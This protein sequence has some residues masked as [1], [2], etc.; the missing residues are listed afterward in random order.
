MRKL[1]QTWFGRAKAD[2]ELDAEIQFHLDSRAADLRRAGM[3][4]REAERKA[5][6]EFGG[7][8]P[9]AEECRDSRPARWLYDLAQDLDYAWRMMKK[10]PVVSAAAVVSLALGIGANT[11]IFSLIDAIALRELPVASPGE[12]V[13]LN[14]R[15]T[16]RGPLFDRYSGSI[17]PPGMTGNAFSYA[18][19]EA[20]RQRREEFAQLATF[21]GIERYSVAAGGTT[22]ALSGQLVSGDYFPLLGIR[23]H[24]GRLLRP[25]DDSASA[26]LAAVVSHRFYTRAFGN[27]EARIGSVIRVNNR[28]AVLVGVTP[29]GFFG[30]E[31]GAFADI[32]LS[33]AHSGEVN[34]EFVSGMGSPFTNRSSWAFQM[35]GRLRNSGQPLGQREA[36]LTPVLNGVLDPQPKEAGLRPRLLLEPAAQGISGLRGLNTMF[37]VLLGSTMLVLLIASANV[38]N[39]LLARAMGRRREIAVRLSI[40]AS[41]G[42][43][44]R[45]IASEFLLL[46]SLGAAA[47]LL[48]AWLAPAWL[49][50][51]VPSR[52][53]EAL[54]IIT[55]LDWRLLLVTFGVAL[56]VTF[57]FGAIPAWRATRLDLTGALK[58]NAG[59][60][61]AD[62]G[63]GRLGKLMIAGQVALSLLLLAG[64][65]MFVRTLSNLHSL[66]LG[67]AQERV[68]LFS[69]NAAQVGYGDAQRG[70]FFRRIVAELESLPAVESVSASMIRPLMG[71]GYWDDLSS[72]KFEL[73]GRK[74]LGVGVHVGLPR[75]AGT[76]GLRVLSGRDLDERDGPKAPRTM[77]V[78]ETMARL[79]YRGRNPVGEMVQFGERNARSYQIVGLVRD[80]RY[81]RLH[82]PVPTVYVA[83]DQFDKMPEQMTF[84]VRLRG[85]PAAAMPLV[86]AAVA[87]VEPNI[88]L[89]QLRTLSEQVDESL[90]TERMFAMLSSSFALLALA[91]SAVGIFGVMAYQAGRRRQ[92][93][94]VRLALGAGRGRVLAMVL[95]ESVLMVV[96][97]LLAGLLLAFG[98]P[99]F[100]DGL[101]FGLKASD[102]GVFLLAALVLLVTALIAAFVPAWRAA[103]LDPMA[104]LREE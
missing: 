20:L 83:A 22:Y 1:W 74:T 45:Q 44:W 13:V 91:L 40:G 8:A 63:R 7:P 11:A 36:T 86:A 46:A 57:L 51:L 87:R 49:V 30:H 32:T 39:L 100:V 78:N 19:Y 60:L 81:D 103:R 73:G 43:L 66:E 41:R 15:T 5:R 90:R 70:P 27:D 55:Y 77:V 26:P 93:I 50:T 72:P 16:Q 67:F 53:E 82:E 2:R 54:E 35:L 104:A 23:P 33:L 31:V 62:A 12:L 65:G 42:R 88:P 94:G 24:W 79:A 17:R 96:A 99:K 28:A 75:F 89:V 18:A 101:L 97:G 48:V 34:S 71:G 92:E 59:S 25:S 102:P 69:L 3:S 84:A 95:R 61:G 21:L 14:W 76:L 37:A 52:G 80:A 56:S 6:L 58:E 38:A 9:I 4:E 98:L 64:A 47:S 29:P 10:S 85:R 68:L